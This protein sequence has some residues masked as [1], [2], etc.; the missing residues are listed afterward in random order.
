[1]H[2]DEESALNALFNTSYVGWFVLKVFSSSE[3]VLNNTVLG[4]LFSLPSILLAVDT[5]NQDKYFVLVAYIGSVFP[6]PV[7][8]FG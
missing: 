6:G 1:M 4:E 5:Q 8:F 7:L 2:S 3:N